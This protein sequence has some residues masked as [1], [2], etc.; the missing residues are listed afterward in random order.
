V[1]LKKKGRYAVRALFDIAFYNEGL[2]WPADE[3]CNFRDR[4]P[5]EGL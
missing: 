2:A 3:P 5:F 1:K 4:F